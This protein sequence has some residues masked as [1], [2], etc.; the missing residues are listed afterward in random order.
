MNA[1]ILIE[2]NN[3]LIEDNKID[4][5]LFGIIIKQADDNVVRDKRISSMQR[6]ISI[7]GDGI[8]LLHSHG[9]VLDIRYNLLAYNDIAMFFY[10]EKG[11]HT[12]Y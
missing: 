9:N 7:R 6:D 12:I 3:T 5:S 11:E 10:G 2:A 8:R 1:G 4:N